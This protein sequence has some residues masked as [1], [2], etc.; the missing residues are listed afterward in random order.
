MKEKQAKQLILIMKQIEKNLNRWVDY[1]YFKEW[2]NLV[3][4]DRLDLNNE[5]DKYNNE[6]IDYLKQLED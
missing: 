6:R 5:N 4:D 3:I 1:G 2:R